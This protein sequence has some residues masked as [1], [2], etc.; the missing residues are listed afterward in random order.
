MYAPVV[1][2]PERWPAP[3]AAELALAVSDGERA[4]KLDVVILGEE[5]GADMSPLVPDEVS[6][7]LIEDVGLCDAEGVLGGAAAVDVA[8]GVFCAPPVSDTLDAGGVLCAGAGGGAEVGADGA[9][10]T[11][12]DDGRDAMCNWM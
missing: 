1:S 5:D 4:G 8:D 10:V 11:I 12:V 9:C 3:E 7:V 6:D 2:P